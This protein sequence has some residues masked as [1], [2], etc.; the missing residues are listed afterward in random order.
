M[1]GLERGREIRQE[2]G[3]EVQR[4]KRTKMKGGRDGEGGKVDKKS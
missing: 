4:E 1:G 3:G 2:D